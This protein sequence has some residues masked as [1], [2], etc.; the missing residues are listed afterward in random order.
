MSGS[1]NPPAIR[2]DVVT[3]RFG[4]R[5]A[6]DH[7]SLNVGEGEVL[8]ILG[9]NGAGKTT[10]IDVL[11]G[12]LR[13][14]GGT[15]SVLGR[16]ITRH[17]PWARARIGVLS[18][19]TALYEEL[20][21][22]HNLRFAAV[23]FG[24]KDAA[25]RIEELLRLTGLWERRHD[26]VATF[27]GGMKRRLA[28]ARALLHDPPILILDEPTVG[29]DLEARHQIWTHIRELRG[30]GRTI[31]LT[32]N[33]LD[34]AQALCDRVAILQAGRLLIEDTPAALIERAGKCLDI[35]C[36]EGHRV[37]LK[38]ALEGAMGVVRVELRSYG[39]SIYL[40]GSHSPELLLSTA[41]GL[42]AIDGFRLRS[43]DLAEVFEM[44]TATPK[45]DLA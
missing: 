11:C 10:L 27:S 1:L 4:K 26:Q 38:E 41:S 7:V 2:A 12:L 33:Y 43:P 23:L 36:A 20:D 39:L 37:A 13:P 17:G 24:V 6:L 28:I 14:D 21:S 5:L 35:D 42:A 31:L 19:E 25:R 30:M 45:A 29:V 40:N 34:E 18:Q 9:P 8:G 16:D 22:I 15:V 44:V 3:C 32:T